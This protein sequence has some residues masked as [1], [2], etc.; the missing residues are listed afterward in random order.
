MPEQKIA[1]SDSYKAGKA[2]YQKYP[3]IKQQAALAWSKA[4]YA[5]NADHLKQAART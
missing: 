3:Q 4:N 2:R 1:S 5:V